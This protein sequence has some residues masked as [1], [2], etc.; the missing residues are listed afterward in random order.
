MST[1][2]FHRQGDLSQGSSDPTGMT[3]GHE[4]R[5]TGPVLVSQIL[6]IFRR[7]KWIVIGALALCITAGVVL[8]MLM[9]PKYTAVT[10][11]EI[12]RENGSFINVEGAE[13][14]TG[15]LDQEFYETQYG[16]LQS[17]ML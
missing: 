15:Y 1:L 11:L 17:R 12:Q 9:T 6:T 4:D 16:L 10:V 14:K 3:A 13:P 5:K 7:R 8:T 2:E